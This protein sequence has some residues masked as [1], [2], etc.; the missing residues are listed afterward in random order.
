MTA[1]SYL[2]TVTKSLFIQYTAMLLD[3][4]LK[5]IYVAVTD[6]F[7]M[8]KGYSR[9]DTVYVYIVSPVTT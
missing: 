8:S 1:I 9:K 6:H 5:F 4:P 7:H 2:E 3:N